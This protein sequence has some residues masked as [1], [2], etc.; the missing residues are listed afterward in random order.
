MERYGRANDASGAQLTAPAP[1][2]TVNTAASPLPHAPTRRALLAAGAAAALTAVPATLPPRAA[3]AVEASAPPAAAQPTLPTGA[4]WAVPVTVSFSAALGDPS[5]LRDAFPAAALYIT[6]RPVG[7]SP[8]IAARR[9]PLSDLSQ[10]SPLFPLSLTLTPSD[11]LPDAPP[12]EAW[13]DAP[14]LLVSARLDVDGVAA[15]RSPEDLI[16]RAAA[17]R[18]AAG[19][20]WQGAPVVLVGRG[21]AGRLA[22]KRTEQ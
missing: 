20:A 11:A 21:L 5:A 7:R 14:Q 15:T 22:T 10:T 19:G 13:Q 17:Q 12:L 18:S 4:D 3:R 2:N 1:P 8:P 6:L 16:G 9:V